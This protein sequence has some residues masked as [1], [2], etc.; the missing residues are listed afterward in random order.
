MT[1]QQLRDELEGW[2]DDY[3]VVLCIVDRA[4]NQICCE[5][6]HVDISLDT[7]KAYLT[8]WPDSVAFLGMMCLVLAVFAWAIL[9]GE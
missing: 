8:H 3:E 7:E 9:K 1:I 2:S 5:I 6:S 4:G